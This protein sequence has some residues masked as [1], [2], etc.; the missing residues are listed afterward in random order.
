MDDFITEDTVRQTLEI[1]DSPERVR[2]MTE[3][4]YAL[5]LKHYSYR[6]LEVKLRHI[7]SSFWGQR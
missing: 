5:C 2:A 3:K 4:N 7:L 6:I 1:L